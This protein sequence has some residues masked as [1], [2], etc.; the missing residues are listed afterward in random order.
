MGAK[1]YVHANLV[2]APDH[3]YEITPWPAPPRL[4]DSLALTPALR[5]ATLEDTYV[6]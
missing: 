3:I 5:L 4:Q 6:Y 2:S 1:G